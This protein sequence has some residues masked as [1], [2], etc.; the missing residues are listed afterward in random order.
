MT[1]SADVAVITPNRRAGLFLKKHFAAKVSA[2]VWAADILSM[3]DFITRLTGITIQEPIALMLDFYGIYREMEQQKADSLEEFIKWAPML[4]KDFNDI[5]ANLSDP[6][7][8]FL[9]LTDVKRMEAWNPEGTPPT[10]FQLKYLAFFKN[11]P[12][13]HQAFTEAI[14]QKQTAYQGL[15]YRQAAHLLSGH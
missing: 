14:L 15:A 6:D 3:E 10:E 5:D 4:I 11:F 13:W 7:Q 2:A 8:L 12:T 1:D 9:N